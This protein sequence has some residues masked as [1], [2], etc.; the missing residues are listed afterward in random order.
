[1]KTWEAVGRFC[2]ACGLQTNDSKS[3]SVC[4]AGQS[5]R[6]GPPQGL[7]LAGDA[8]SSCRFRVADRRGIGAARFRIG[9]APDMEA[10][11]GV[12]GMAA[13]A[14]DYLAYLLRNLGVRVALE[15][16]HL[17]EVG[18]RMG[19]VY[20]E[21][22]GPG[23]GVVEEVRKRIERYLADN[24]KQQGLPEALLY[25]PITAGG[26]ALTHPLVHLAAFERARTNLL[27]PAAPRST[28]EGLASHDWVNFFSASIRTLAPAAPD[29][30]P[31][32]ERLLSDFIARGSKVSGRQ[33]IGLSAY[34]QWIVYTYGPRLLDALGT[35]RFL[36]TELVPLQLIY[37]HRSG[38]RL[39]EGEEGG[40]PA[41]APGPGST[42]IAPGGS[43]EIPF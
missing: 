20:H 30:T 4:L 16:S 32:M 43:E 35:F 37:Q 26:L 19:R 8:V 5:D 1:M 25:W 36:L 28:F 40:A 7:P 21:L 42:A 11:P 3:G 39:F 27:E 9:C 6:T 15:R 13:R 38:V 41:S 12:L 14:S 24:L 33:Q 10:I 23:H 31:G 2:R 34:W 17:T 18:R 29:N 22:F